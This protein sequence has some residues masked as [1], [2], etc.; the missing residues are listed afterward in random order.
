MIGKSGGSKVWVARGTKV[1]RC[2][3][4]QLRRLTPDQ[5]AAI[6]LMPVDMV[7]VRD[8]VSARGAGNYIDLS[9]LDRPEDVVDP[10]QEQ[11]GDHDQEGQNR[12]GQEGQEE[13]EGVQGASEHELHEPGEAPAQ[14]GSEEQQLPQGSAVEEQQGPSASAVRND[15]GPG[16]PEAGD[17]SPAKR[18]RSYE[19]ELT[20]AMRFDPELLDGNRRVVSA[21]EVPVPMGTETDDDLEVYMADA[22][23]WLVDHRRLKL[24]RVH[25]VER[26]SLFEPL[27]CGLPVREQDVQE[28]CLTVMYNRHGQKSCQESNWHE[29]RGKRQDG[30]WTGWTAFSLRP[31][32]SWK[33]KRAEECHE[34]AVKTK[35]RK[36]VDERSLDES[37]K[38][39]LKAAKSKEW[40]K[41]ITSGAVVVHEGRAADEIRQTVPKERFL[42][43]RFVVTEADQ[44]SSPET[45]DLKARWCIRGYLDPDLL[46]LD[47]CSPTISSEGFAVALQVMASMK[48][49][50]QIADVEGA[51]LRGDELDASRGRLFM[52]VPPGGIEGVGAGSVI[53]AIKTVYGLA[54]APRAWWQ[55]FSKRLQSL[56]LR[57]SRFDPCLFYYYHNNQLA[58][59]IALH[60]DDLCIAGSKYFEEHVIKPLKEMFPF[61]HWKSGEGQFLGKYLKQQADFSITITQAEYAAQL[62]AI[63]ISRERRRQKGEPI[64]ESERQQMRGALGGLNWL[65]SGSRPDLAAWSSLM[66]QKVNSACVEDLIEVNRIISMA[67]DDCQAH[68]WIKSI[69]ASQVQFVVLTDAAWANGKDCCS[70]AGYMIAASDHRLAAGE[71]GVFSILRWKSYKQDRQT[72]STLGAELLSLSRGLAEA[73][74]VRSMWSEALHASYELRQDHKWSC[75]I[76]LTAVID[77]KPVYDHAKSATVSIKDK[78]MAIE[79]LLL[80]EDVAKYNVQLRWMATKQMIV[81]VLTKKGAPMNLFRKVVKHA[82][83]ILVEDEAVVQATSKKSHVP[84]HVHSGM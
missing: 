78:R 46:E 11:G 61:K 72:H 8:S 81:D 23:H 56:G 36:E 54:D 37:R 70:Q 35:G 51:F 57:P 31:G 18:A 59:V 15:E 4:E 64:T 41:L 40:K 16:P 2:C 79:M 17:E 77:C 34:V 33:D 30:L 69:P 3:P 43:S 74:W 42:K 13:M 19:S 38:E 29:H 21:Q 73:R 65:V 76:P 47:T 6:R 84:G 27:S 25:A 67:H 48:W 50:L 44:G 26:S 68:I 45:A 9:M 82:W 39:G 71:W 22:D 53:E 14:A 20:R 58:G 60:V 28:R 62:K 83:F 1:Y 5:E 24:I 12:A 49:R 63:E 55:C 10:S 66:Q 80:K 32:W 7:Q 52:E 75:A